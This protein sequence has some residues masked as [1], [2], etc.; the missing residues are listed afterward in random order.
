MLFSGYSLGGRRLLA[1]GLVGLAFG[2]A[3]FAGSSVSSVVDDASAYP[4]GY[5]CDIWGQSVNLSAGARCVDGRRVK[6]RY[7]QAQIGIGDGPGTYCVGAKQNSDGTGG[8]TMAFGC[9]PAS[10][11]YANTGP[12]NEVNAVLGYATIINTTGLFDAFS[13]FMQWYP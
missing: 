5:F 10:A 4:Q 1:L 13:G 12:R 2:T 8:N 9:E 6:H 11:L 3:S 7:I